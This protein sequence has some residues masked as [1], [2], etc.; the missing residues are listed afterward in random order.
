MEHVTSQPTRRRPAVGLTH[1]VCGDGHRSAAAI[2]RTL[3]LAGDAHPTF[4]C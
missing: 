3:H 2:E 1:I 4:L